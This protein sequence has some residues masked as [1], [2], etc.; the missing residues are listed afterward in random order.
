MWM[1]GF[2]TTDIPASVQTACLY[3]ASREPA[4]LCVA[5][6]VGC[7]LFQVFATTQGDA[8]LAPDTE[9]WLAPK[10]PYASALLQIARLA[11]RSGGPPRL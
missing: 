9:A 11:R 5:F 6:T 10:G 7:V 1:G 2:N 3:D 4:A 8:D